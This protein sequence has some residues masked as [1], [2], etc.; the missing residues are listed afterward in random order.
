[1]NR[2]AVILSILGLGAATFGGAAWYV[3]RPAPFAKIEA[4]T[5][6]PMPAKQPEALMRSYSPSFGPEDAP[7]TIVE[8]FDPAC[9][10]ESLNHGSDEILNHAKE[11][12]EL[13]E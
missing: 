5:E 10:R 6:P 13:V 4:Q 7:V 11:S 9:E 3:T 1:M 12:V 8:F 2:R